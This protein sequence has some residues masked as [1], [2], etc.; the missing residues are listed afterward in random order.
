MAPAPDTETLLAFFRA[1]ADPNRLRIVGLLAQESRTV[2]DLA[3]ALG[4][5][6]GTASHHLKRLATVGLVEARPE[7]YYRFYSLREGALHEMAAR[8]LGPNELP[9]LADDVDLGAFERK[10]LGTF[11][12]RS[13]RITAFPS[14]QKKFLVVLRHVLAAFE[15]GRRYPE[16]AVNAILERYHEDTARLRRAM[17]DHGYM[18]REGGGGAYWMTDEGLAAQTGV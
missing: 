14:Q 12:D 5:S 3:A 17:V 15:P 1:L 8:L 18:E 13:G 10:I 4:T 2:E 16:P 11:T 7:G 6:N 9:R